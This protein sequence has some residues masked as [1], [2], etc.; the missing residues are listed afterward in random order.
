MDWHGGRFLQSLQPATMSRVLTRWHAID[1]VLQLDHCNGGLQSSRTV[2]IAGFG[3][4][5]TRKRS[6]IQGQ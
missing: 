1:G 6:A 5:A 3:K 2:S 4:P